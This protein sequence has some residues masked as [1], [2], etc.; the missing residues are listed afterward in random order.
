MTVQ[1]GAYQQ[2]QPEQGGVQGALQRQI[3]P[4]KTW[5]WGV[6]IGGAIL[7][8]RVA[9]GSNDSPSTSAF[10]PASSDASGDG[11][12]NGNDTGGLPTVSISKTVDKVFK[13]YQAT[14]K[15]KTPIRDKTGKI[16]GYF[17][18][19]RTIKLGTPIKVGK[20]TFYPILNMPGK[21]LQLK[22]IKAV[23]TPIYG[24]QTTTTTTTSTPPTTSASIAAA[25]T[26]QEAQP[27]YGNNYTSPLSSIS[28]SI[29]TIDTQSQISSLN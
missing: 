9:R 22:D 2:P 18:P 20:R 24:N 11:I 26:T 27:Y 16:I 15:V 28:G 7:L 5:Q 23:I 13:Y 10:V 29:P 12:N 14:L 19:G 25:T 3:G 4:L 8:W 17:K 6:A 21:Y 1:Q